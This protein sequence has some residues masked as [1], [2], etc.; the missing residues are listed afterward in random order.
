MIGIGAGAATDG[1]VLVFHD[2]LGIYGGH[3]GQVR[4]ALRRDLRAEMVEGVG[5]YATEVRARRFPGAEHV[6]SVDPEELEAFR[7]YLDQE[8][9]TRAETFGGDW[10]ATEI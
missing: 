9:L 1:Q 6:Y 7:R 10:S 3:T 2:L 8:S 5:A 4:E